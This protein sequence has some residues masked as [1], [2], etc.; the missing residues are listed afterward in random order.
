MMFRT[1]VVITVWRFHP[2][3]SDRGVARAVQST[4]TKALLRKDV[5]GYPGTPMSGSV[6]VPWKVILLMT[7]EP[8]GGVGSL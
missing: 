5:Q 8:P 4:K 3:I 1:Y 2:P 6:P 7:I